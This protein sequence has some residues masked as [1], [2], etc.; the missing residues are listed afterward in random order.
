MYNFNYKVDYREKGELLQDDVYRENICKTFYM[1][2]YDDNN[3]KNVI[4]YIFIFIKNNEFFDTIKKLICLK[5]NFQDSEYLDDQLF[6]TLFSFDYYDIFHKCLQCQNVH[7]H[8]H[9]DL[10]ND[11]LKRLT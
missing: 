1:N 7:S 2:T 11:F 6:M 10:K 8:I 9:E 5:H 4:N 3:V